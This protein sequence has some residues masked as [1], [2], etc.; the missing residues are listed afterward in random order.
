MTN[1]TSGK[2]LRA[3]SKA[4]REALRRRQKALRDRRKKRF[5]EALAMLEKIGDNDP[6]VITGKDYTDQ[7]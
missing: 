6:I 4:L 7:G 5:E 1:V 3:S 2:P